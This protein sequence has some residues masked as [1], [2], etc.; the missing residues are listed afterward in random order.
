VQGSSLGKWFAALAVLVVIVVV[1]LHFTNPSPK[2]SSPQTSASPTMDLSVTQ[3]YFHFPNP[4]AP[5]APKQPDLDLAGFVKIP[6]AKAEEYLGLHNRDAA[7]LLA[8]FHAL[9]DMNYLNEAAMNFPDDPQ[10]Q[11]TILARN[12]FP[13]NRRKWLDLFKASSPGN[14]LANYLSAEDYF[15]NG[16]G[17]DAINELLTATDKSQFEDY[18]TESTS[19]EEDLCRFSGKSPLES[20]EIAMAGSAQDILP[21]VATLK[22][23]VL[24]MQKLQ[25]Q[26]L[27]AGDTVSV[28]NLARMG[29]TL[30]NQV[31]SG[32]NGKHII[33]QIV[34]ITTESAVL[35]Q[36]DQNTSYDFL[37]GETP[38]Q[39]QQELKQQTLSLKELTGSYTAVQSDLTD[40][41]LMG[42]SERMKAFGEIEAM[43]WV[44]Q[45]HGT[46]LPQN[47]R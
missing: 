36:L 20:I 45:Q 27:D 18:A 6:R 28:E 31:R 23:L 13:E 16:Q 12:A 7:S 4:S 24:D 1:A 10:V 29:L 22:K 42:F 14:S 32:D 39:R 2:V 30:A 37:G 34:G 40:A 17:D 41:E 33:N 47:S 43:R 19:N 26:E 8:V 44:A 35:V 15:K 3:S 5:R 46:N 9:E 21:N 25:K 11:W 38:S